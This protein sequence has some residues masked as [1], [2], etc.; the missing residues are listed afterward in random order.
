MRPPIEWKVPSHG[1]PSTAWPSIWPSRSF[2][3]RAALLV[4]VT[5]RISLRPRPALAQDVGDARGQHAGLAG[6]GAGQHQNRSVQRL[7]RLAL[8]RIE[9]GEI[10]RAGR[11]PRTRGDAASRGL[12]LGDAVMGQ[13]ARLGHARI[14]LPPRWH[15]GAVKGSL[16]SRD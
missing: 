11:G 1:M 8:L 13:F 5:D 15:R 4:K 16:H 3:S 14:V 2:I 12:V 10:L 7:H 6:A 9:P